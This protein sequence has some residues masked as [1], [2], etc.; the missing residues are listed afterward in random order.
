MVIKTQN[1]EI[2]P[3]NKEHAKGLFKLWSDRDVIKYTNTVFKSSVSECE[4]FIDMILSKVQ[5]DL[6]SGPFTILYDQN[7]IGFMGAPEINSDKGEYRFFYQL[8]KDY[9]GKGHGYEAAE[10][11]MDYMFNKCDAQILYADVVEEN[12]YSIKILEKL[13]MGRVEANIDEFEQDDDV[14]NLY[15]Y[16]INKN[17]W[18]NGKYKK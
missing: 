7:V 3:T 15:N 8:N 5:H 10:G 17:E 6:Y 13:G 11:L 14:Q 16:S 9:W 12:K 18:N 2:I 4:T 1:L